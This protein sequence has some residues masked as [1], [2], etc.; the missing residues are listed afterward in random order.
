MPRMP[1]EIKLPTGVFLAV[2][3]E[4]VAVFAIMFVREEKTQEE[5]QREAKKYQ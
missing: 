3:R 1:R 5:E 4:L 2:D